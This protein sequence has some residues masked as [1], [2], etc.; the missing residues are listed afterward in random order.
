MVVRDDGA[1]GLSR[2]VP[3]SVS[4]QM[5]AEPY[6]FRSGFNAGIAFAEDC[7]PED[8]PRELLKQAIAEGKRLR[9]YYFGNFY[10]VAEESSSMK[11]WCI[12]QYHRPDEQDG[13]VMAFRRDESPYTGFACDLREID[14]DAEY[15]VTHSAGY[16]PSPP[17]RIAGEQLRSLEVEIADR[18][19]SLVVEYK[20]LA[21]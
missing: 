17:Q 16:E 2:F 3:F 19:G 12:F 8:Y 7:R 1:A 11:Q 15:E 13:L 9:K 21:T 18:P 14:P 6:H 4:G 10:C 5:G 20:R